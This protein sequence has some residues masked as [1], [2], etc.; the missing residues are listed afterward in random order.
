MYF[1]AF[2]LL[3]MTFLLAQI[4]YC[5]DKATPA[6]LP[7]LD[8]R[9]VAS[10]LR[11]HREEAQDTLSFA[12]N[13]LRYPAVTHAKTSGW[14]PESDQ[15]PG[16]DEMTRRYRITRTAAEKAE[17][18]L[19]QLLVPQPSAKHEK[20]KVN[21]T[22]EH[23][24]A[25][26]NDAWQG[27]LHRTKQA[28]E[29]AK[30]PNRLLS[31][32]FT[33]YLLH[34]SKCEYPKALKYAALLRPDERIIALALLERHIQCRNRE[35]TDSWAEEDAAILDAVNEYRL[36]MGLPVLTA[37]QRLRR[38]CAEHSRW[39]S[40]AK[41]L[42]HRRPEKAYRTFLQRC[43]MEE[44][45]TPC[46]E[47]LA[48]FVGPDALSAWRTSASHQRI[49]LAPTARSVGIAHEGPYTALVTG[50]TAASDKLERLRVALM[51]PQANNNTE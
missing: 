2:L 28:N 22:D 13:E 14:H 3:G 25:S 26:D 7:Q 47:A 6:P 48:G 51:P 32:A 21:V 34:L 16:Q 24:A 30:Q 36:V 18:A 20:P 10:L 42:S 44:V 50:R 46:G 8:T 11:S 27:L 19:R 4:A 37:D 5:A 35:S 49:L 45:T 29:I 41:Q 40:S 31:K 15:Q 23:K 12:F 38:V 39:M 17:Q 9:L 43:A 1:R 33:P